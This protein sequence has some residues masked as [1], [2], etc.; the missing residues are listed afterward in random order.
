MI[1]KNVILVF[2]LEIES[3]SSFIN[4]ILLRLEN[5]RLYTQVRFQVHLIFSHLSIQENGI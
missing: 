3:S 2:L 4:N 1:G 5:S